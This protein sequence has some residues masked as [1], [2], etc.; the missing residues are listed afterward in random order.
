MKKYLLFAVVFA[1]TSCN[2]Q[3]KAVE[4]NATKATSIDQ[5]KLPL[6]EYE[7]NTRGF[8]QKITIENKRVTVS[9]DR[10]NPN[11]GTTSTLSEGDAIELFK[12]YQKLNLDALATY[13][14]PTQKRFY[15][16]AAIANL[17]VTRNGKEYKTTDF[18][19]GTPPEE[20]EIFVYKIVSLGKKE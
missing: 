5:N 6:L 18:D 8:F 2:C 12:M 4:D 15:D 14:D 10:N 16:G 9:S 20:I 13:K 11:K 1:F 17:K 7:A 3:K 19:H